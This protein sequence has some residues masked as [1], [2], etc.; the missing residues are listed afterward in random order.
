MRRTV[1]VV[2]ALLF[3]AFG[4]L[5]VACNSNVTPAPNPNAPE[6]FLPDSISF[7]V[8]ELPEDT[9]GA[10]VIAQSQ[11]QTEL[12]QYD[13]TI[14]AA[15]QVVHSFQRFA[16]RSLKLAA[17]IRD[18]FPD[19]AATQ[20]SGDLLVEGETV[21]YRADFASFDID[22]DGTTEGSGFANQ[23]PVALR[24]WV[25]RGEGFE[26]FLCVL[27]SSRPTSQGTGAGEMFVRPSAADATVYEDLQLYVS[28]D[29]TDSTHGWNEALVSGHVRG[30]V[31][32][33]IGHQRV[34]ARM[35]AENVLEKTVRSS[36]FFTDNPFDFTSYQSSV[37]FLRGGSSVLVSAASVG[38]DRLIDFTDVCVSLPNRGGGEADCSGFNLQDV[39]LLAMPGEGQANFPSD[40]PETPTF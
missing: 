32:M 34:D 19:P 30:N 9:T 23:N 8:D 33:S 16:D 13:R 17:A 2:F 3:G 29:R 14:R 39:A 4:L 10:K 26:R 40:F 12:Q 6:V 15:S 27:I 28:W 20:I 18:D 1:S 22:S 7:D 21:Q 36:S 5:A 37:H 24:M 38:G 31:A 35:N 25:D 11:T